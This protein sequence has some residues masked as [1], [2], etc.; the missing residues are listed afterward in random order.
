MSYNYADWNGTYFYEKGNEMGMIEDV[1]G[2]MFWLR[3]VRVNLI[4]GPDG[5]SRPSTRLHHLP[6]LY[7]L[8]L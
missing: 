3:S 4:V 6:R 1:D 8:S 7:S 2:A 5:T